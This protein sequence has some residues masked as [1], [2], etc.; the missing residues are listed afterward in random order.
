VIRLF[1]LPT[2]A[3]VATIG[4]GAMLLGPDVPYARTASSEAAPITWTPDTGSLAGATSVRCPLLPEHDCHA[5]LFDV[6]PTAPERRPSQAPALALQGDPVLPVVNPYS[7][8]FVTFP[9]R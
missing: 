7:G 6:A 4:Y 1:A 8:T 5:L 3:L 2:A 9:L